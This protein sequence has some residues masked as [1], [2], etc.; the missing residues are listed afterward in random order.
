VPP[1]PT[2]SEI[3]AKSLVDARE[4]WAKQSGLTQAQVKS[5]YGQAAASLGSRVAALPPS[6]PSSAWNL[7]QLQQVISDYGNTLDQRVLD[8]MYA[9][10]QASF[11]DSADSVLKSKASAA[12]GS[13][14]GP[15]AVDAHVRDVNQ[16]AAA[17]YMTRT[18]KDGIKLS[19]RVWKTN[20]QWRQATQ[21]V[22]QNAVIAGQPPV[23]V[24]R[25][26]EQY[27]KPGVNV[28]Y[29]AETAKRLH[30]PKDTSMPA[31]RVARTEM[32]NSFHEGTIS[33]HGSMPSYLGIEWHIATGLGHEAD[34]CDTYAAQGF[35]PKGTE[36]AKPHPHCFCTALPIH[37]S[38]DDVLNDLDEWLAQPASHPELEAYYQQI[39]PILDVEI[40]SVAGAAG[41]SLLGGHAKGDK[42]LIDVKGTQVIATVVGEH[43]TK[44]VLTLQV[45]PGQ[46]M[47]SIKVWR[48]P[49]KVVAYTGPPTPPVPLAAVPPNPLVS[50]FGGLAVGHVVYATAGQ[51]LGKVGWVQGT[52]ASNGTLDVLWEDGSSNWVVHQNLQMAPTPTVTPAVGLQVKLNMP[53]QA[54]LHN[55]I[56]TITKVESGDLLTLNV[57]VNNQP[58]EFNLEPTSLFKLAEVPLPPQIPG[59]PAPVVAPPPA[60]PIIGYVDSPGHPQHGAPVTQIL[61]NE[62]V[63]FA[64]GSFGYGLDATFD[65][66]PGPPPGTPHA[67]PPPPAP[68]PVTPPPVPAGFQIGDQVQV[69]DALSEHHG[70]TGVI[71]NET[72]VILFVKLAEGTII[73]IPKLYAATNLLPASTVPPPPAQTVPQAV[74]QVPQLGNINH[75]YTGHYVTVYDPG[76]PH[77]GKSYQLVEDVDL[78]GPQ[79]TV[80]LWEDAAHTK[81]IYLNKDKLYDPT[82]PLVDLVPLARPLAKLEDLVTG[83]QAVYMPTGDTVWLGDT[84]HTA[85]SGQV[86]V[87]PSKAAYDAGTGG[88][89]AE[90]TDLDPV[91]G[92]LVHAEKPL[93][94]LGVGAKV[95]VNDPGSN[96][97]GKEVT[98]NYPTFGLYGGSTV[99]VTDASGA[100]TTLKLNELTTVWQMTATS[101]PGQIM[102][103]PGPKP[104]NAHTTGDL[105]M[106]KPGIGI[107]HGGQVVELI[108]PLVGALAHEYITVKLGDGS[109][110]VVNADDL[111]VVPPLPTTPVLGQEFV[112]QS[113][114]HL[115]A[116]DKVIYK[117]T[118]AVITLSADADPS[119]ESL[120]FLNAQGTQDVVYFDEVNVHPDSWYGL[121]VAK[122]KHKLED[123]E[124][125]D[126]VYINSP[127]DP[128]HG[129]AL[130]LLHDLAGYLPDDFVDL[131]LPGGQSLSYYLKNLS[132]RVSPPPAPPAT[133]AAQ[134]PAPKT[135]DTVIVH[136]P[137]GTFH[138]LEVVLLQDLA[139]LPPT[140]DVQVKVLTTDA[141]LGVLAGD[142]LYFD[143]G[144]LKPAPPTAPGVPQPVPAPAGTVDV[145]QKGTKVTTEYKGHPVTGTVQSYNAGKKVVVIKPDQ[146]VPG[147]T[148]KTFTKAPAKVQAVVPLTPTALLPPPPP[149][150]PPPPV[151][152]QPL[153]PPT[154]T[155]DHLSPGDKVIINLPGSASHGLEGTLKSGQQ[156]SQHPFFVVDVSGGVGEKIF[157][158]SELLSVTPPPPP[159]PATPQQVALEQMVQ[160]H[161][162]IVNAPGASNHGYEAKLLDPVMATDDTTGVLLEMVSGPNAGLT[163]VYFKTQLLAPGTP[164]AAVTPPPAP[165]APAGPAMT[166]TTKGAIVT[167]DYQGI[168]VTAVVLSYNAGKKVVNLKPVTPVPGVKN[169]FTKAPGKVTLVP[170]PGVTAAPAPLTPTPTPPAPVA[171]PAPPA[172]PVLP[173]GQAA[174][175]GQPAKSPTSMQVTHQPVGGG[176]QKTIYKA[177]DGTTWMFKPDVNAARA[178]QA[179]YN[180][181]TLL[182]LP[183]PELHVISHNGQVGSFQQFHQGIKGEVTLSGIKNLTTAQRAQIQQHQVVDWLISQHDSNEGAMLIGANDEILAIDKGQ[184][185]KFLLTPGEKLHWTYKPNPNQLVY[186]PLF[187]GYIGNKFQL[188]RSAIE[189][190]LQ[191]IEAL[192]DDDFKAAIKPYVDH[193]VAQGFAPNEAAIY[194]KLLARKASLRADFDKLYD[195]AD[196]AAGRSSGPSLRQA[197][198]APPA[199]PAPAPPAATATS[200]G[201]SAN[202]VTPITPQLAAEVK[203]AGTHGKS[204]MVAGSDIESGTVHLYQ[205]PVTGDGTKLVISTKVRADGETKLKQHLEGLPANAATGPGASA[206][207]SSSYSPAPAA[208]PHWVK[209]LTALKHVGSHTSATGD[210]QVT[211]V[212]DLIS[213]ANDIKN[214]SLGWTG[215]KSAYYADMLQKITGHSVAE[216]AVMTQ[217]DLAAKMLTLWAGNAAMHSQVFSEYT[218]P[219]PP[220]PTPTAAAAP[221][222][223]PPPTGKFQARQ[224]APSQLARRLVDGE[225]V[226]DGVSRTVG[227]SLGIAGHHQW[228]VDDLGGGMKLEYMPHYGP[229]F[230]PAQGSGPSQP[231]TS[232]NPYARQGKLEITL[233]NWQG[234]H[235]EIEAALHKLG[236]LGLEAAPATPEDVELLYLVHQVHAMKLEATAKYTTLRAG[237]NDSTPLSEQIAKHQKYLSQELGQDVTKMPSYNPVPQF[238]TGYRTVGANGH[239]VIPEVGKPF[240]ERF[241]I[242]R[243]DLET[244]LPQRVLTHDS[245]MGTARFLETLLAGNG[246]M[247][248]TEERVRQALYDPSAAMS[249]STDMFSGGAS[250]FFTRL[251]R[252]NHGEGSRGAFWFNTELL[253]R[254]DAIA[255]NTD[256]YGQSDPAMKKKR[257]A[258]LD[259]WATKQHVRSNNEVIIKNGFGMLDYLERIS[260]SS[261]TERNKFIKMFKDRGITHIRGKPVED[262]VKLGYNP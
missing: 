170:Q 8:A 23:Q 94:Q 90:N 145:T 95:V 40:A 130:P 118:G 29:K 238:G 165:P 26:I 75:L 12:F 166:V 93:H 158:K 182:G 7:G 230:S 25:Q 185:F 205:M 168:P 121:K 151:Q 42:V 231:H 71:D 171:V 62:T 160:G 60:P 141:N 58:F 156:G 251:A 200:T 150:A 14:F 68:A 133:A 142:T 64:D 217:A 1:Q 208:D 228:I 204:I 226:T 188:E 259:D 57:T 73:A 4:A 52:K 147:L 199:P 37:R 5:A 152:T 194:T 13:V 79:G 184:A 138:G 190:I 109:S 54:L 229:A 206:S 213:L 220:P 164:I 240:F 187:E 48:A 167:T 250:Y 153:P 219:P 215:Q 257:H 195:Q 117:T 96:W 180:V 18:G 214:N 148:A 126:L 128:Y 123:F 154:H 146:P 236:E 234:T 262:I 15:E 134:A 110:A 260:A 84:P 258:T 181:Q 82:L 113:V 157:L 261:A 6:A 92:T 22:V 41:G 45:D 70:K 218:P 212:A 125:G 248:N 222:A 136:Q 81:E 69:N 224:A 67:P 101:A 196:A 161:V 89:L 210:Q 88:T 44:G 173:P 140:H 17:A 108:T 20:A 237:I 38:S 241:D 83:D 159:S 244:N 105:V 143:A 97:H 169:K 235:T 30:V 132:A 223:P 106:V 99:A 233:D 27:L 72:G 21:E 256:L 144:Q 53:E 114:E 32:Q 139:G 124:T 192:S 201:A 131:E 47:A 78:I 183:T 174:T 127:G 249:S 239:E 246:T 197:T 77:D 207:S 2:N 179:G 24:A 227:G 242:T 178:E 107:D 65:I 11:H 232:V 155:I 135:G 36:P 16:R 112:S 253:L 162:V 149:P 98:L 120:Y 63:Q 115:K 80:V 211:K 76:G 202:Q 103:A 19:D 39:K 51:H 175:Q 56:A 176:H 91:P 221:V 198:T 50:P 186:Q 59:S 172:V 9:G 193:A 129:Q 28:P 87:Y 252:V 31:M 34:I 225:L 10:I 104:L 191:K 102:P 49:S 43:V 203:R 74:N 66:S 35:F 100:M 55:Q 122:A 137:N 116:G 177:P 111:A 33:S 61:P 254:T 189:P 245:Q 119:S 85:I 216:V 163:Y 247:T 46:G 243:Q 86:M 255:Y 3:Y 209:I